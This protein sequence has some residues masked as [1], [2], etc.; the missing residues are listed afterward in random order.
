MS[1]EVIE[2]RFAAWTY[3]VLDNSY[4]NSREVHETS[5]LY[6]VMKADISNIEV[7]CLDISNMETDWFEIEQTEWAYPGHI[8]THILICRQTIFCF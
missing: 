7:D 8:R 2:C 4:F 3:L 5:R 1:F 6:L